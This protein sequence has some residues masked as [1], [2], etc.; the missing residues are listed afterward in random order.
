MAP[1]RME[2]MSCKVVVVVAVAVS[3][4]SVSEANSRV[5]VVVVAVENGGVAVLPNLAT[6]A[7]AKAW[8]V[9]EV[10]SEMSAGKTIRRSRI[11]LILYGAQVRVVMRRGGALLM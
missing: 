3:A 7:G 2:A 4:V 9:P 10:Y 11:M 8:A 6:A 5:D 1:A